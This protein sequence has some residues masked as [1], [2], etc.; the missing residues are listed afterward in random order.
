MS[1]HIPVVRGYKSQ[2]GLVVGTFINP[3]GQSVSLAHS[4][5]RLIVNEG[6]VGDSH[7]GVRLSDTREDVL[8]AIGVGKEVPMA[9]TR[10]VS[11]VSRESLEQVAK[12]MRFPL[13][14]DSVEP[15]LLAANLEIK[16]IVV[17]DLPA[18]ALLCFGSKKSGVFMW[19]K[20]T[21]G[22]WAPNEPCQ[23]PHDNIVNFFRSKTNVPMGW[24]P[25]KNFRQA[26]KGL[27]GVVGFVYTSGKIQP[28]DICVA[29]IPE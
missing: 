29:Y 15:S 23:L 3:F 20:A 4:E 17:D 26:A 14:Y 12:N 7:T 9:N 10:Q 19:H 24:E 1:E 6:V 22:I 25:D 5:I 18:G 11:I 8:K 13:N 27:R 28:G 2:Q 21:I 16:G